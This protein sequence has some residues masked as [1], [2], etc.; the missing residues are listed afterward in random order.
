MVLWL[1]AFIC[2]YGVGITPNKL[3]SFLVVSEETNHCDKDPWT[4]LVMHL[5]FLSNNYGF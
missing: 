3:L 5:V 2:V 4:Y 1:I